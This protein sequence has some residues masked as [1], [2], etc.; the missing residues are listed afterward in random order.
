MQRRKSYYKAY[1]G[2]RSSRSKLLLCFA[3]LA[4]LL[5]LLA[6]AYFI[7][8]EFIVFTADGFHFTFQPEPEQTAEESQPAG[9][10]TEEDLPIVINANIQ[11]ATLRVGKAANVLKVFILPYTFELGMLVLFHCN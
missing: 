4:F 11:C 6:L 9:A 2:R 8:P 10:G 7:L 3:I 5:A 1:K